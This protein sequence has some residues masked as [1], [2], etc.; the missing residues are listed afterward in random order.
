MFITVAMVESEWDD[1]AIVI[2]GRA[3]LR[4]SF[5][6]QWQFRRP[7][8]KKLIKCRMLELVYPHLFCVSEFW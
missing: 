7:C 2:T 1:Y 5:M 6:F 8:K 4:L 3:Y